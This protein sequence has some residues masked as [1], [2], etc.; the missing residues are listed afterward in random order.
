MGGSGARSCIGAQGSTPSCLPE[1]GRGMRHDGMAAGRH[2]GMPMSH[3]AMPMKEWVDGG[4][5]MRDGWRREE[6]EAPACVHAPAKQEA[7]FEARGKQ[8]ASS[9]RI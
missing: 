9:V 8:E 5:G 7:S 4:M 3:R 1:M 2:G 6:R